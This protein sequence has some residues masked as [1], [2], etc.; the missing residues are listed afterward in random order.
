[1]QLYQYLLGEISHSLFTAGTVRT[2]ISMLEISIAKL[3]KSNINI[4]EFYYNELKLKV[5]GPESQFRMFAR[6]IH[7]DIIQNDS[8]VKIIQFR[9]FLRRYLFHMLVKLCISLL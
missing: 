8:S 9:Y 3:S 5:A 1:M 2:R 6:H 4:D 7:Y